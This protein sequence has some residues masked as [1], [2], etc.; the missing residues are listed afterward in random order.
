MSS[1][2]GPYKIDRPG[3][4]PQFYALVQNRGDYSAPAGT[5]VAISARHHTPGWVTVGIVSAQ[6]P[7]GQGGAM[8]FK[9]GELREATPIEV[10][11]ALRANHPY[12]GP[13]YRPGCIEY[14]DAQAQRDILGNTITPAKAAEL[15]RTMAAA[16]A[17]YEDIMK[18]WHQITKQQIIAILNKLN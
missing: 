17:Q 2:T 12:G 8:G 1:L 15:Q 6:T 14:T 9:R 11:A 7:F 10:M 3:P 16:R 18:R 5:V 4:V 13:A